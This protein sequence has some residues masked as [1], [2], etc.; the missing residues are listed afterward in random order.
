MLDK[1]KDKIENTFMIKNTGNNKKKIENLAVGIVILIITLITINIIWNDKSSNK[2]TNEIVDDKILATK[3]ESENIA[4]STNTNL[5]EKL[6]NILGKIQG[7]GKVEVL[8]TYSESS[9]TMAMYNE[10]NTK[11]DTEEN[12][13]SGG[14]R[15]ISQTSNKKEIIYQ[16]IDGNKIPITQSTITPKVEGAIVTAVGAKNSITK[17]NIIQAVEAVTGLAAHKIQVF[18]MIN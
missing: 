15:K 10:D 17:T 13:T 4:T 2:N 5:E 1:I 14:N 7:V 16:E 12:D 9:K 11:S 8:L 6:E 3:S 18:E